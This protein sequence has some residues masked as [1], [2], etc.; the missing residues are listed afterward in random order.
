[1][2]IHYQ[3]VLSVVT[4]SHCPMIPSCSS[5]GMDAVRKH[6]AFVGVMMTADHLCPG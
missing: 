3:K 1:M 2:L 4:V 5:Y 6:G